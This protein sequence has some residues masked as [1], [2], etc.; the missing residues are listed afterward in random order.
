LCNFINKAQIKPRHKREKVW[1]KNGGSVVKDQDQKKILLAV[2]GSEDALY[3]VRYVSNLA[4][5][6]QMKIV[7]FNVFSS[8]PESYRDLAK[9]PLFA[10]S[11]KEIEAWELRKRNEIQEYMDKAQQILLHSGITEDAIT[12]NIQ[13]SR[14][15]IA[16]D[17]IQEAKENYSCVVVGR[18]GMSTDKEVVVGSVSTKIIEKLSFL[19]VLMIGRIPLDKNI[20]IA[21]DGSENAM[22]AVEYVAGTLGGFDFNITLL[23]VIR[24]I[25]SFQKGI[26]DLFLPKAHI[27]AAEKGITWVFDKAKRYLTDS[28]FKSDQIKTKTILNADSRAAAIDKEARDGD[29][30]TIVLGRRGLSKVEEFFMGRVSKKVINTIRN[31]SVWVVT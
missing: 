29:Y 9:D 24:G 20:L 30:S 23:Y 8:I 5:F 7:L 19:P 25:G 4:P 6:H 12:I 3:A 1:A 22:R 16:R 2:D 11:A 28:G 10:Q 17:I 13:N 26:P 18:K 14:K 15:G 27:E 21:F 31:R